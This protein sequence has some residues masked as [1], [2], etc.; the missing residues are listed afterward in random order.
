MPGSARSGLKHDTRMSPRCAPCT[1]SGRRARC[2][3]LLIG[4]VALALPCLCVRCVQVASNYR[5]LIG[6]MMRADTA[7]Q[8][9]RFVLA[10]GALDADGQHHAHPDLVELLRSDPTV[11]GLVENGT[12]CSNSVCEPRR[13]SLL[14]AL[15]SVCRLCMAESVDDGLLE[16]RCTDRL[17]QRAADAQEQRELL[18]FMGEEAAAFGAAVQLVVFD[19]FGKCTAPCR[20]AL[21]SC[22]LPCPVLCL[23][24]ERVCAVVLTRSL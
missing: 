12:L 7:A 6:D 9:A 4:R 20:Y 19:S 14:I 11:A 10:G 21:L 16:Q 1:L 22:A 13:V 18:Q 2:H 8:A 24:F 17:G 15:L 5:D 23:L 3:P